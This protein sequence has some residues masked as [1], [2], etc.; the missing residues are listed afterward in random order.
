LARQCGRC[1][2]SWIWHGA[3]DIFWDHH[4]STG[5][6]TELS[7]F[8]MHCARLHDVMDHS[9]ATSASVQ[10]LIDHS[11]ATFAHN[12]GVTK[13]AAIIAVTCCH[14]ARCMHGHDSNV[15]CHNW[16]PV[17]GSCVTRLFKAGSRLRFCVPAELIYSQVPFLALQFCH[18]DFAG[19][20]SLAVDVQV[21]DCNGRSDCETIAGVSI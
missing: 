16:Q 11:H 8:M 6:L 1:H 10:N 3:A 13:C 7:Q 9:H 4:N 14:I 17:Q 2:T 15:V 12:A 20:K 5:E 21:I 19:R 18:R